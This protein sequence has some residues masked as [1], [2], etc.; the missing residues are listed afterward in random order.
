MTGFAAEHKL[1]IGGKYGCYI[2][3]RKVKFWFC[4]Q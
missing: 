3:G 1:N 4:D 2:D